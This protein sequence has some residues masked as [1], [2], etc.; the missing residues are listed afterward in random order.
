MNLSTREKTFPDIQQD[1]MIKWQIYYNFQAYNPEVYL[2]CCETFSKGRNL[3]N[4][5][6]TADELFECV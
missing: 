6:V 5:I 1:I 2:R 4:W 3:K